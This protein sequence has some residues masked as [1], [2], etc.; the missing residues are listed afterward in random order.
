MINTQN[1][2]DTGG[3]SAERLELLTYLLEE[4]GIESPPT[5]TIPRR[6]TLEQLPL[7]FA[8]Q[9][10]WFLAQLEPESPTYN[11]PAAYRLRGL[12]NV[13]ALEQSLSEI[14]RRHETLRTTFMAVDGQAVQV[15]APHRPRALPMVDLRGEPAR[16]QEARA[17]Q[18]A[19]EDAH[20]P[21]DLAQGPL[22]RATLVQLTEEEYVLLLNMHHIV[23][24]GWSRMVLF[25]ELTTFYTAFA[26]GKPSPLPELPIQYADYAVWQREWLQGE[27]LEAQLVYWRQQLAGPLPMLHLPTDRP[28][29]AVQTSWGANHAM[30]LSKTLTEALNVISQREGVTLYMTLLAAFQTLLHRYTGQD[31]ITVGSPVAGR[32]RAELEGLIGFFVNTLILRTDLSGNPTFRELLG[33]VR[34]MALGAYAHQDLPF[35]R[36]VEELQPQRSLSHP[37]LFQVMFTLQNAPRQTLVLP[38]LTLR[39]LEVNSGTAK[40]DL[41]LSM[42]ES[43]DGL[44]GV[45]EYNTDLFVAATIY[46]LADHFRTLLEGLVAHPDQHLAELP[47]L[48]ATERQQILVEWNATQASY[49]KDACIHELF[50]AQVERTPD[51]VAVVCEGAQ[52]TYRELNARANQLAHY[53]QALGVGPERLVGICVERSLELVVGLLGILKAGGAYVPLDP[54]YPSERLAF[55][56]AD[57]HIPVLVTQ[58]QLIA[59]LLVHQAR[60]VCLDTDWARIAQERIED[61]PS[62]VT[63][64]N[65][66]YVIYT[67]GSTGKPK[68][69]QVVHQGVVN[70][71]EA[72]RQ[73]PGLTVHDTLLAVTILSFDIAAL[74]LY[75]PLSVGARLVLMSREGAMD[76]QQLAVQLA[77][78]EATVMQ[79]T[80]ATWRLLLEAGWPG[81]QQLNILCGG[82]ALPRELAEQLLDRGSALWNLY[83]PT[84]TTIW[85]AVLK[86]E[87]GEGPVAIGPP[88]ANTEIYLLDRHLQPVAVGVPGELYIGGTG[89]ARGY[90]HRPEL[91]AEK[92]VP[93][94]Y[95]HEP[96]ARLYRTGDLARYRPDGTL[97]FL[98][99]MDQQVKVRGFRI[100][101]GE[102]EAALARHPGIAQAVA[103]ARED[104]PGDT[105]LVAYV[106]PRESAPLTAADL[107][108]FLRLSLPDYMVPASLMMVDALPLTPNGKV[109]RRALPAPDRTRPELEGTFV[110]PRTPVEEGVARVWAEVLGLE[111]V[112]V[113]DNFF[114]LGGHSLLA[115][116][117]MA[118]IHD[119]FQVELPLR[120]LFEEPT[121]AGLAL[122][123]TQNQGERKASSSRITKR[124]NRGDATQLLAHLDQLSAEEVDALLSDV[125]AEKELNE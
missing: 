97:E 118:G 104:S 103:V 75:L 56:L 101:L 54:A 99:R 80:P 105:R 124:S 66:A 78:S 2:P 108:G 98:G 86:V 96:G 32:T 33:G 35:E 53:L 70:F 79:A 63:A 81:N 18:L 72:M 31:D 1:S 50:E 28:R 74:E 42:A 121:V 61:P 94:L 82:E 44:R 113:H 87:S 122:A 115:I 8:Q 26:T 48:T 120:T 13:A 15:V 112:G 71:L 10:L 85:S 27:V 46:R 93:S 19:A 12:L 39:R 114:E 45:W 69:V 90:L 60:V 102:I 5:Q 40:F 11:I 29:P 20:R 83:G 16:E 84:E 77:R 25:Q 92:F 55:M 4:E 6:G 23:S 88:I 119:I 95:S 22:F 30:L 41:T 123:V 38:G 9:R 117:I 58:H 109:D 73:Q 116:R 14:V 51:T 7:S 36:L 47:L 91:T 64:Q 24:D 106:V 43:A 52:L 3:L 34:E 107:R 65:L 110:A 100:E 125:L 76:G 49:P 67:S 37:P 59:G 62:R 21:F 111:R 17:L 57:A 89:L 68:G